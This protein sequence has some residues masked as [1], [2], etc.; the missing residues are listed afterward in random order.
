MT[1]LSMEELSVLAERLG[2]RPRKDES[3]YFIHWGNDDGMLWFFFEDDTHLIIP[4]IRSPRPGTLGLTGWT[5]AEFFREYGVEEFVTGGAE[6]KAESYRWLLGIG[7][8]RERED[9]M[10]TASIAEGCRF[11]QYRHWNDGGQE[12][13]WHKQVAS[14]YA[15]YKVGL[16]GQEWYRPII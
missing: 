15:K 4:Q 8:E 10:L 13:D 14:L 12:P 6:P 16:V 1:K 3:M 9:G 7:F 11:D 5:M 2:G